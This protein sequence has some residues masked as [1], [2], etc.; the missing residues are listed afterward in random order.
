MHGRTTSLPV[1]SSIDS[2]VGWAYYQGIE[3]RVG[4]EMGTIWISRDRVY[5]DILRKYEV[6]VDGK[7]IGTL[8]RGETKEFNLKDGDHKLWL[9]IDWCRS[10]KVLFSIHGGETICFVGGSNFKGNRKW[11]LLLYIPYILLCHT[12][13]FG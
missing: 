4:E 12:N 7:T 5:A 2:C 11:L 8:R 6:A 9:K 1:L 10:N 13:I 3:Q